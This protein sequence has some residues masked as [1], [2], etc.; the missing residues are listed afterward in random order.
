MN[1]TAQG[2]ATRRLG[3]THD[4]EAA[5][6][7]LAAGAVVGQGFA[8]FYVMTS[9]GDRET[10]RRVNVMKGRPPDQVG[11]IT[12]PPSRIAE[13]FDW[14][15]L[16]PGLS[17]RRVLGV[18]DT[19]YRLG[20]FGFRGPAARHLPHHLTLTEGGVRTAQVIA[21]GYA[22]PSNDFLARSLE[23]TG[24]DV[25]YVTSANRSR[26]LTGADDT[27]AHWR[28]AGLRQEFGHEM[29]FSLLEHDDED[30]ARAAYPGYLPMSTTI[31]GFHAAVRYPS[32][33]P[34]TRPLLVLERHGS[35]A[36][37]AVRAVLDRLGFEL[38]IAPRAT[39][40]LLLREYGD[41]S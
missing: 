40:R 6:R 35:L 2:T 33:T 41:A 10:V 13:L 17:R 14:D 32:D 34:R 23:A 36:A 7:D 8:N 26:H 3:D 16:P 1:T 21:P 30:A 29:L 24:E 4:I 38:A 28:A 12:V 20:P 22:C 37:D 31:L 5:A 15:A 11:S 9:R 25:L 18:V 27:P 39:T 19:L